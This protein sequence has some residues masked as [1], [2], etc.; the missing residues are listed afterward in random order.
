MRL[1]ECLIKLKSPKGMIKYIFLEDLVQGE[2]TT[3]KL[4][5]KL[6]EIVYFYQPKGFSFS[7]VYHDMIKDTERTEFF[8]ETYFDEKY[9]KIIQNIKDRK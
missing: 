2:I 7:T 3:P 5:Q 9:K 6:D 4:T 1:N 8:T